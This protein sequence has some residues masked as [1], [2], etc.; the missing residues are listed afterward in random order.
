MMGPVAEGA[1]AAMPA[2]ASRH[3]ADA[4][5]PTD[6][7]AQIDPRWA[8]AGV[9]KEAPPSKA[10]SSPLW[11]PGC[12]D[13]AALC[14]ATKQRATAMHSPAEAAAGA[15]RRGG[16]DDDIVYPQAA[17]DEAE[18]RGE[19]AAHPA[20]DTLDSCADAVERW[21]PF[22]DGEEGDA[23]CASDAQSVSSDYS[24]LSMEPYDFENLPS[25]ACEYCGVHDVKCVVRCSDCSKWF[26]N[27]KGKHTSAGSHIVQHLV[28]AKHREVSLHPESD[29]G[30]ATL[31]CYHCGNRNIFI[32]GYIPA[33]A[34]AVVVL[35]CRQPCAGGGAA[36]K[37]ATWDLTAWMPLIASRS[38]LK[39][40]VAAPSE[41]DEGRARNVSPDAI[42][43]LELLRKS[44]PHA[45]LCDL[46]TALLSKEALSETLSR[47]DSAL[48]FQ[49][50]MAP[51]IAAEAEEDRL[52][53]EAQRQEN[54]TIRWGVALNLKRVAYF[55]LTLN[56]YSDFRISTGD[57]V[58][59]THQPSKWSATG[60][61]V[62]G[63]TN[64]GD[65]LV[66]EF[67]PHTKVHS[68]ITSCSVEFVWKSISYDR[69]CAA[70]RRF[71]TDETCI[72]P[73]IA[74][75]VLGHSFD[76]P[77][78]SVLLPK[79]ISAP[80]LPELN[81]SQAAA[82]R[83]ALQKPLSLIQGPPGTGK[84]ITSATIAYHL[85]MMN[86][87]PILVCAP[88]N[89]A[90]DHLTEKI[91]RTGLRVVRVVSLVKQEVDSSID[92]LSLHHQ[93]QKDKSN[94]K[95]QKLFK[96][97][98][99]VGGLSAADEKLFFFL[100]TKAERKILAGAQ[101]ICTTS[102]GAG[103]HFLS[104]I[105]FK[106]ILF[107]EATQASKPDSL[108]SLTSGASQ[109]IL[110]GDHR[111]LGPVI[112]NKEA[113]KAGLGQSLFE[114]LIAMGVRPDRLQV[115]Y[116]MHP[117]LAEFPSNMFYDGSLQNGVTIGER[118]RKELN[119]QW[120]IM[121]MPMFFLSCT[122][123]EEISS[124]GTS[125]LNR[126]EASL[127][128]K[129]VTR[130]LRASISPDQIGVI[131]PY[132][133]QSAYMRLNLHGDSAALPQDLYSMVEVANVDAFQGRE[134]EYIIFSCVRS[135]DSRSIGFLSDARRLNVALTRAKYGLVIVG[136]PKVLSRNP[137]W[138]ALLCHFK[139]KGL[140][141]EGSLDSLRPSMMHLSRPRPNL[142][143]D[144]P[145]PA[146]QR[147]AMPAFT[148][149]MRPLGFISADTI[150]Q[151]AYDTVSLS[152][153]SQISYRGGKHN[154]G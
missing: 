125:Y 124:S 154:A 45:R 145:P 111:Q 121:E 2:L 41:C 37:D 123:A 13:G 133:G 48:H 139:E 3:T 75:H 12:V 38:L 15:A 140:L 135:S 61:I 87:G 119:F 73:A 149:P 25:Y 150:S 24:G 143:P 141:V 72:D 104:H 99:E 114:W 93:L 30:D 117:C 137:L 18:C 56:S 78:L 43:K 101:I 153:F 77:S 103:A 86:K 118:I 132:E 98:A 32:L 147:S 31:E 14:A 52:N 8:K 83:S 97:K 4:T 146:S 151:S 79:R 50:I 9:C 67:A 112:L 54:V 81:Y 95:L 1:S 130:F 136:N 129:I 26:C 47:Y 69:M 134:K 90:V 107:D 40:I 57:E 113:A 55:H 33:K 89:V 5:G 102:I 60:I 74:G 68:D 115:Q 23:R 88:T 58:L 148:L 110:I 116:R 7:A 85:A 20:H 44:R 51:L 128:S 105:K 131:T 122:G 10:Q 27:G 91:H 42:L 108:I 19:G 127:V 70:L 142:V 62:R 16:E 109:V 39:W 21:A 80:G 63:P 76:M 53:K 152:A 22:S 59:M 64:I 46:E 65:E 17:S 84:T 92:F 29:L 126:F 35:L 49:S 36:D 71:A 28:R 96:L 11:R 100:R 82:V 144:A 34:D 94:P 66:V 6:G 120:P 138:N 106:A